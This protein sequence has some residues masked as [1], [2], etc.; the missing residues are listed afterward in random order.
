MSSSLV[1]APGFRIYSLAMGI[2]YPTQ[3]GWVRLERPESWNCQ[4]VRLRQHEGEPEDASDP[5]GNSGPLCH[6]VL[7]PCG[8][9]RKA[10]G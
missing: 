6:H 7:P 8:V 5:N 2:S 3:P 4:E 1:K 10:C 9:S